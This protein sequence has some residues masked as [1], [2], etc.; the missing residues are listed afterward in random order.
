MT[1][2]GLVHTGH[3]TQSLQDITNSMILSACSKGS[4]ATGCEINGYGLGE[5]RIHKKSISFDS[6][7]S[8]S[9]DLIRSFGQL[10]IGGSAWELALYFLKGATSSGLHSY[11]S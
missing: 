2:T 3:V 4:A 9:Q 1:W 6:G 11:H 8:Q 7:Y 10:S 5:V